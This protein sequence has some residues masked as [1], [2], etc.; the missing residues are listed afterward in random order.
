MT[1]ASREARSITRCPPYFQSSLW[2]SAT[3]TDTSL[4]SCFTVVIRYCL[5]HSVTI[6]WPEFNNRAEELGDLRSHH[7]FKRGTAYSPLGPTK[8]ASLYLD[9]PPKS[10]QFGTCRPT[11]PLA[12]SR[13]S[14][15]RRVDSATLPKRAS[16]LNSGQWRRARQKRASSWLSDS[17]CLA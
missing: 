9:L 1:W 12:V 17:R 10:S 6:L 14:R 8:P 16:S 5:A 13:F 7:Q 15:S 11:C 3:P 2:L 4:S